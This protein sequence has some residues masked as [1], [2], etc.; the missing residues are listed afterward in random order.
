M[1]I[2]KDTRTGKVPLWELFVRRLMKRGGR[3]AAKEIFVGTVEILRR[4]VPAQRAEFVVE[5]AVECRALPLY[6]QWL[7][8]HRATGGPLKTTEDFRRVAVAAIIQDASRESGLTMERRLAG[9]ILRSFHEP[10][11]GPPG[12][13]RA[14][15]RLSARHAYS[16]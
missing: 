5:A 3:Q 4:K 13:T 11:S 9:A 2:A 1:M 7:L 6:L 16:R 14:A 15:A 10:D 8:K 12:R